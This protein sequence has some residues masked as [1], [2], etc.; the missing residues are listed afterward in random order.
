MSL[1]ISLSKPLDPPLETSALDTEDTTKRAL[2]QGEESQKGEPFVEILAAVLTGEERTPIGQAVSNLSIEGLPVAEQDGNP[3]PAGTALTPQFLS[4]WAEHVSGV[5]AAEPALLQRPLMTNPM[6][7]QVY[8]VSTTPVRGE[9]A[10]VY[11]SPVVPP[12]PINM[13]GQSVPVLQGK[14]RLLEPEFALKEPLTIGEVPL[15]STLTVTTS[16]T[17]PSSGFG[18][19]HPSVATTIPTFSLSHSPG[20][21]Q[22]QNALG[23]RMVWLV[24]KDLQQAELRLNPRH[25]GPVEV[26]IEIRSEQATVSF[27]AHHAVTRDVLE[28]SIP[29]LREMFGDAGVVL[30][31]VNVSHQQSGQGWHEE[32]AEDGRTMFDAKGDRA[33]GT[34]DGQAHSQVLPRA[35]G[36]I[37][38]F[39]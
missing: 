17:P 36:L 10:P 35:S 14:A 33:Q 27:S 32:R 13:E 20:S 7:S 39:A 3:L 11:Q 22:W 28:G 18:T 29:R 12:I 8:G 26:R 9:G 2:S 38:L 30:V 5:G 21:P 16:P 37:D 23:E 34:E 25:L 19:T 6:V 15:T 24:K 4:L 31:D 1:P